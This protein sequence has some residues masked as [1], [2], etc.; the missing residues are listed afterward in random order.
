MTNYVASVPYHQDE[1]IWCIQK[2]RRIPIFL[3]YFLMAPPGIWL[4][5]VFIFGYFVGT[6]FY[7]LVQFDLSDEHRN[8]R[9]WH[10]FVFLVTLPAIIGYSAR[11][12][13]KVWFVRL[14]YVMLLVFSM[15]I[16]IAVNTYFYNFMKVQFYHHQMSSVQ[17]ILGNKFRFVGSEDVLHVISLDEMVCIHFE[18]FKISPKTIFE[19]K[20]SVSERDC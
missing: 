12:Q 5:V 18:M 1:W 13:P 14:Y 2:A 15:P 17:E 6:I 8:D 10:Y 9:D 7:F 19:Y 16:M 20:F 4:T 3:N 11:Y